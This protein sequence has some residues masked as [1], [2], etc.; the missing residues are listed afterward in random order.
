[1]IGFDRLRRLWDGGHRDIVALFLARRAGATLGFA[2]GLDPRERVDLQSLVTRVEAARER[3]YSEG[4]INR[5]FA[6]G[7]TELLRRTEGA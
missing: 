1:M 6:I 7:V 4:E 3:P 5:M 2:E